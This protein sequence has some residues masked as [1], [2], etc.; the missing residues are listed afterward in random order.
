ML[1]W[2]WKF[3]QCLGKTE[4]EEGEEEYYYTSMFSTGLDSFNTSYIVHCIIVCKAPLS[5]FYPE[6]ALYKFLK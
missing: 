4:W 5:R 2:D 6:K 1:N 3:M